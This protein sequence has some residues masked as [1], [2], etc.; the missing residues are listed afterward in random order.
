[1]GPF[2]HS[3]AIIV[4]LGHFSP[5]STTFSFVALSFAP[6][7]TY[8]PTNLPVVL[9][10]V[11]VPEN[12]LGGLAYDPVCQISTQDHI[13]QWYAPPDDLFACFPVT[14]LRGFFRVP[15]SFSLAPLAHLVLIG[16]TA[17]DPTQGAVMLEGTVSGNVSFA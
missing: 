12:A 1:M 17:A 4:D 8:G 7:S 3:H 6:I 14:R 9:S 16:K 2:D 11:T 13:V 15:F 5:T 10:L